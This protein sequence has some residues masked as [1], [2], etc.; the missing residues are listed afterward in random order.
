M[1]F[2]ISLLLAD[3]KIQKHD[4]QNQR[5]AEDDAIRLGV[6]VISVLVC[7]TT[8]KFLPKLSLMS[9]SPVGAHVL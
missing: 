4:F 8:G 2:T 6:L 1:F 7:L 5:L 9:T 3:G